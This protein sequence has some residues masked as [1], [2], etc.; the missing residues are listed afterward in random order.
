MA[1]D[2][3]TLGDATTI[4]HNCTIDVAGHGHVLDPSAKLSDYGIET[5]EQEDL[6]KKDVRTN[7]GIGVPSFNRSISPNAL[8]DLNK[9]WTISKLRDVVF[10]NSVPVGQGAGATG[11][12]R[13]AAGPR[14][15]DEEAQFT[16]GQMMT[17]AVVG[18]AAGMLVGLFLGRRR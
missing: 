16:R 3:F 9:G 4:A 8:K 5:S 2:D 10:D 17:A 12:T 1:D 14:R 11:V 15:P 7:N 13:G 18:A 6:L